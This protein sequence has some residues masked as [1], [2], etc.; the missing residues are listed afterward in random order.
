MSKGHLDMGLEVRAEGK[1]LGFQDPE[2]HVGTKVLHSRPGL[3]Q[4]GDGRSWD[5][6]NQTV[7]LS[8]R[9][10]AN[11]VR[12]ASPWVQR[13]APCSELS[14]SAIPFPSQSAHQD[15]WAGRAALERV[16]GKPLTD[17]ELDTWGREIARAFASQGD[18]GGKSQTQ[19]GGT[20]GF[21]QSHPE[22]LLTTLLPTTQTSVQP[23]HRACSTPS[24]IKLRGRRMLLL[25]LRVRL[26]AA[27]WTVCCC[28]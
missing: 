24:G 21:P 14:N 27:P 4:R 3:A 9:K 16:C 8:W 1:V 10:W 2:R 25:L 15:S 23:V 19:D 6:S 5:R 26:F 7:R 28:C 12:R 18:S 17:A 11:T 13:R 22:V 20:G